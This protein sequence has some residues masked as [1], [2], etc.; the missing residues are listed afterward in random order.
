MLIVEDNPANLKLA[1]LL[2]DNVGHVALTPAPDMDGLPATPLLKQDG[3]TAHVPIIALA[4]MA[5]KD[6]EETSQIA[7]LGDAIDAL[8]PVPG[9]GGPGHTDANWA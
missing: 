8:L 3:S 5:M 9:G 4:A 1:L 7:E 6:D 2:L